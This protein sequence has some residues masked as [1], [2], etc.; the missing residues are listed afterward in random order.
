MADQPFHPDLRFAR[1][2]PRGP[3]RPRSVPLIRALL[4][5]QARFS[6]EGA[7]IEQ[8]D[9]DV[10]VRLSLPP[11]GRSP[12]PAL[13]WIHGGG[14][15]IGTA[16]MDDRLCRRISDELDVVV[17]SVEYRLAPEHPFPTPLD[18]CAAA[19]TWLAGRPNVDRTRIAIGGMSAGGGLAAGL[20]LWARDRSDVRP[21]LQMLVYP[22]I[23]DRTTR[24]TD[25]DG[26]KL[27]MWDASS[28]RYGWQSYLG[29]AAGG[30]VSPLA[31]PARAS[32]LAGL[33]PAWIGVGTHDLFHDEDVRYAERL[34]A[35]GV[36][37][38][39]HVVPGAYHGFDA[40][41][42]SA[43]VSRDFLRRQLGALDQAL[44]GDGSG[45]RAS[46]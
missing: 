18:D 35:A 25:V 27:R 46:G 14:M 36:P 23:D 13:L 19:L 24:R 1:L 20:S 3:I 39:L 8:V 41:E 43:P 45:R 17:A 33:P 15:V 22:M 26:R 44:N 38:V 11:S 34:E 30:D 9:D 40:V 4:R 16:A 5:L 28:N 12:A 10:A 6:R 7:T 21:V 32:D 2:L 29:D 37:C 42:S 31:A